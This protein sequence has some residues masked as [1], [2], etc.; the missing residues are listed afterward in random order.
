MKTLISGILASVFFVTQTIAMSYASQD[1]VRPNY[2]LTEDVRIQ[3]AGEIEKQGEYFQKIS[4]VYGIEVAHHELENNL[5]FNL[6]E[7]FKVAQKQ[8]EA[9][10]E[11]AA[12]LQLEAI[13]ESFVYSGSGISSSKIEKFTSIVTNRQLS[14]REKLSALLSVDTDSTLSQQLQNVKAEASIVGYKRVFSK[15][16]DELRGRNSIWETVVGNPILGFIFI[17]FPALFVLTFLFTFLGGW[18]YVAIFGLAWIIGNN[19]D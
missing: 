14:D 5:A 9:L 7:V 10:S 15:M 19:L 8:I 13:Q 17:G 18:A 2:L 6:K 16:A 11:D 12:R 1:I 3:I 4:D